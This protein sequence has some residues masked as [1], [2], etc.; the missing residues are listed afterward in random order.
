MVE[1]SIIIITWKMKDLIAALLRS[2][3]EH[4]TG[5]SY[6]I[7]VVDNHSQ[8]GTAELIQSEFPSARL[9]QNSA[10]RGVAAARNQALRVANGRFVQLLDADML[11][12]E[13]SLKVLFDFMLETPDAGISGCRLVSV[14]GQMHLNCR[15]FPTISA[16]FLRR[17]DFLRF[18]RESK[19][20]RMHTMS[21]WNH[22]E[23]LKVDYL[24]GACQMIRRETLE[25]VG[26]LDEKIFYGPE[27]L[28]FCL[29]AHRLGWNV[30]YIPHTSITHYEQRITKQKY[31]STLSLK[32]LKGL[33]YLYWKYHG[34]F[35]FEG[36]VQDKRETHSPPH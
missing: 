6:E 17:L 30:Y 7:I 12:V 4:T 26:L 20:L 13:N 5:I 35:S 21:D 11:L 10:N 8:D 23:I 19:S 29:R 25:E 18:A 33:M 2:I 24:I 15:R 9:I 32:H 27:D 36:N 16:H 31:F 3:Q 34:R 1:L 14:D 22:D 28:D